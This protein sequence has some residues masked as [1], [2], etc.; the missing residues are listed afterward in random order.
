VVQT[1]VLLQLH[2]TLDCQPSMTYRNRRTNYDPIV[3]SN[4]VQCLLKKHT[5]KQPK[6]AQLD[7]ML[8]KWLT[9]MCSN[10]KPITWITIIKKV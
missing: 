10:G 2:T 6:L 1:A 3:S 5:L 8:P 4:S 7:K 9:A